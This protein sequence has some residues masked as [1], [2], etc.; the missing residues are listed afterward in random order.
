M[1]VRAIINP[2]R[3]GTAIVELLSWWV[4]QQIPDQGV[5]AALGRAAFAVGDF[6]RSLLFA[7]RASDT[8]REEGRVALLAQTLVL[9]TFAALY[10]GRWEITHVASA[11]AH[12][13]AMETEQP[14]WRA[15][16]EL[17]QANLAGLRGDSARSRELALGVERVAAVAGNRSLLNGV[18][19]ARGLTALGAETPREAFGEFA[20]MMNPADEAYHIPQSV[21]A[22]DHYADA[23]VLTGQVDPA[24]DVLQGFEELTANTTAP[25]VQR[26]L[27]IARALLA[28]D[29]EAEA[30][31]VEARSLA[32][33]AS[34]WYRGRLDLAEGSWLRRQ[35]RVS[36]SR[37]PLRSAE[38][39]F[40]GLNAA[41]WT[42][43]AKRELQ[44][45]GL[46]P[47]HTAPKGWA[48]L[49]AQELQIAQLAAQGLSN[50]EI[51]ERL[52]LS[53]RT[54]GSHLY[55]IFP[56]LDIRSRA[57]LHEAL[58]TDTLDTS[59]T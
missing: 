38:A 14:V 56:K 20:R 11:E 1:V 37:D 59:N 54:V 16:A 55:R 58:G 27:A 17:G 53:P 44:A 25:G 23:A 47:H 28:E 19:L 35:R 57:Q 21:W 22:L 46:R 42:T 13:F 7:R 6:D 52:Y 4:D 31:F 45:A 18:Q 3:A 39:V 36:E 34:P 10:L 51:G 41:A 33:A 48:R 43:R 2:Y 49:S 5:A 8:F 9:E 15:V 50:R 40:D 24:R 26:P 32:A 12:R 30:H 29:E